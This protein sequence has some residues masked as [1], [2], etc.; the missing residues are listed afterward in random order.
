[1]KSGNLENQILISVTSEFVMSIA[2]SNY[3]AGSK[4]VKCTGNWE[5][6]RDGKQEPS[7]H[8]VARK[9]IE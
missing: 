6:R 9:L 2:I 8:P 3:E 4:C 5:G 1:L 7:F